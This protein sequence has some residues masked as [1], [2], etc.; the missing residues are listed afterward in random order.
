MWT[1]PWKFW[2]FNRKK[3]AFRLLSDMTKDELGAEITKN[4]GGTIKATKTHRLQLGLDVQT[5]HWERLCDMAQFM[6]ECGYG[7]TPDARKVYNNLYLLFLD[8]EEELDFDRGAL[9]V[10]LMTLITRPLKATESEEAYQERLMFDLERW[11]T[12]RD[13]PRA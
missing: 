3:E 13:T 10:S 5:E 6:L 9:L 2:S 8:A 1:F 12:S 11:K 7:L 4:L